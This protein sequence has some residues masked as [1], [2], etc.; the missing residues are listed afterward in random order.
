MNTQQTDMPGWWIGTESEW[1]VFK[2][3]ESLGRQHRRDFT[4]TPDPEDGISF[5]FM[6]PDDL[7]I[8]VTG[9]MHNYESGK[10]GMSHGFINKQQMLGLGVHLIFIEDVALQQDPTYYIS[11]AL[12][13][14]DHSHMG[15]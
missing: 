14:R 7:A 15:G 2:I 4:Y 1:T 10:D 5:R 13:Y 8:N 6:N 12:A 9:F 3:L 11:E